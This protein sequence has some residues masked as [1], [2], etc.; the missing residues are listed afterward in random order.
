MWLS[1]R[2]QYALRAAAELTAALPGPV[3]AEKIA[4]AQGIPRRFLDN[5][6]LQL[7]RAV[8]GSLPPL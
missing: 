6:L 7:R 4:A 5:I 8:S 2:T 1:A 3:S